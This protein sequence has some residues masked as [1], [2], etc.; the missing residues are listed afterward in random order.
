MKGANVGEPVK[1]QWKAIALPMSS[2]Y[3]MTS[4]VVVNW[5]C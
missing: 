1:C 5:R 4:G 3:R 2:W